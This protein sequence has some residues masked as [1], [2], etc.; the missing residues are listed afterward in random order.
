M[1]GNQFERFKPTTYVYLTQF[2]KQNRLRRGRVRP[3]QL[4]L[5]ISIV[6]LQV[7]G[8]SRNVVGVYEDVAEIASQTQALA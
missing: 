3:I 2:L 5:P 7:V 4:P 6:V 1:M 8:R